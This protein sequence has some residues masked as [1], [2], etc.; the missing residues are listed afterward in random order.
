MKYIHVFLLLLINTNL[1][2]AQEPKVSSGSIDYIESFP[3]AYTKSRAVY[4]W[5]P[6][7]YSP[8]KKYAVLY[9]HDGQ[10]LFDSS[11][12]WNH[13]E[14]H[15]DETMSALLDQQ[16]IQDCIVVG[17]ANG[18]ADRH[19]EYCPLQPF[20]SLPAYYKDSLIYMAKR[21]NG[22]AL[23]SEQVISDRYLKFIV[24]E[25]KPFVD[26]QYSTYQDRSHTFIAGSSMGGLISLY[27]ICEY[28]NVF[29]GAICM[30]TH[31]PLTFTA[32]NNPFPNAMFD[33]MSRKL[34][35][36]KHHKIYFDYGDQTLD[37]IYGEFQQRADAIMVK[38]K[39][40]K[41]NWETLFFSGDDHSER[42][43]SKRLS[44]SLEFM[45]KR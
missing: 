28:P 11:I 39:F 24:N 8:E 16:K 4:I 36:P 18:A 30:S 40:S 26:K 25:L 9:M 42:S 10:M 41:N 7:A 45:L 33:Y 44:I 19:R 2:I 1:A 27:A 38:K 5:K 6:R 15:V 13:Q 20:L 32:A 23:F 35:N 21:Q 43:W 17:I 29:G 31:W 14:W 22:N 34:P 37:A 3:S 12:T